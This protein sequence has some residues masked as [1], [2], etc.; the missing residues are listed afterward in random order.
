MLTC[1]S[2]VRVS[3]PL[4]HLVSDLNY[5]QSGDWAWERKLNTS[6]VEKG[7]LVLLNAR[8]GLLYFIYESC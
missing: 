8:M 6:Q 1:G 5:R 4:L 2:S 3:L 7:A